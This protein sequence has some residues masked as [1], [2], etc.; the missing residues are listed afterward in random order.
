[1]QKTNFEFEI[2]LRDDASTD[3]TAEICQG[4][5]KLYPD[6]IRLMGY[7]ENQYRKGVSPFLDNAKRSKG[8]YIAVCEGDDYWT[9]PLKLQKQV[10]YL[11]TN[12]SCILTYHAW[13]NDFENGKLGPIRTSSRFLTLVFRN[14]LDEFSR[15]IDKAPNVD[16]FLRFMLKTKG[17]F[18]FIDGINPGIRRVHEGGVMG[19]LSDTGKLPRRI[20]T[21]EHIY[22]FAKNT[23][24]EKKAHEGLLYYKLKLNL[25]EA[26]H[27]LSKIFRTLN[28]IFKYGYPKLAIR[29][30]F[31]R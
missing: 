20:A 12:P 29:V 3:G 17:S 16:A 11:E 2:L 26:K 23:Q 21:H 31:N 8:K 28:F 10:D 25:V 30:F 27:P 5:A 1:M 9:D 15:E 18:R 13:R 22:N 14:V 19:G 4:F 7:K 6:K 24:Y